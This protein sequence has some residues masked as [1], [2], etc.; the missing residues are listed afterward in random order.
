MT[1]YGQSDYVW[2]DYPTWV[3]VGSGRK[4]AVVQAGWG[5]R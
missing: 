3:D 5:S 2:G 1:D 4:V